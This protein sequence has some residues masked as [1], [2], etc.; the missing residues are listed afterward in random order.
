MEQH[1]YYNLGYRIHNLLRIAKENPS[2]PSAWFEK[3]RDQL[4]FNFLVDAYH[5]AE[6]PAPE[7]EQAIA[8]L[9]RKLARPGQAMAAATRALDK[10]YATR[11]VS[12]ERVAEEKRVT[13]SGK[14]ILAGVWEDAEFGDKTVGQL[15]YA[16]V[17]TGA[18]PFALVPVSGNATIEE[19]FAAENERVSR[20]LGVRVRIYE[21]DKYAL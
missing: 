10:A 7:R 4:A 16:D 3:G 18:A 1:S 14:P 5:F 8:T 20:D 13:Q 21:K 19:L 12:L 2:F 9:R 17:S 15:V 6:R 11:L